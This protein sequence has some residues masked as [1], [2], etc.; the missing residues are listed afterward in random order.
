MLVKYTAK[1]QRGPICGIFERKIGADDFLPCRFV[2]LFHPAFKS[3]VFCL[4]FSYGYKNKIQYRIKIKYKDKMEYKNKTD[5]RKNE[6]RRQ[7]L[8]AGGS[9]LHGGPCSGGGSF[10]A[11]GR[12]AVP[13]L[14]GD[15][16]SDL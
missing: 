3:P 4:S 9:V 14:Y 2:P 8:S 5:Q 1:I 12:A 11:L 13:G 16:F 7:C 10:A 15:A 6:L